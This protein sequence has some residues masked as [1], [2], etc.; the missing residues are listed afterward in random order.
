MKGNY[1]SN[2]YIAGHT[3]L[4]GSALHRNLKDKGYSNFTLYDIK[5]LDLRRQEL[6]EGLF[7]K[8]KPEYVFHAAAKVG[9][10]VANNTY[11]AE[12]I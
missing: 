10:I 5:Q 7:E 2:I 3:G 12:F 6:V 11:K 4:V 8:H 1:S 9:G